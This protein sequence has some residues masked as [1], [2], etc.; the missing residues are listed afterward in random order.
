MPRTVVSLTNYAVTIGKRL[1][2]ANLSLTIREGERWAVLGVNGCGKS[3]LAKL[4]G[5][6]S[7]TGRSSRCRTTARVTR[8]RSR[9][10]F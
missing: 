3:T 6:R 9:W 4:L 7:P 10:K 5:Q 8:R 2:V 1:L